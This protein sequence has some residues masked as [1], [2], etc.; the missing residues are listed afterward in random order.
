MIHEFIESLLT[1]APREA[2]K[3]GY[4]YESI[5]LMS[6]FGRHHS[7]WREHIE[8]CHRQT[9]RA[10]DDAQTIAILGS[11]PLMEIPIDQ[12]LMKCE[13]IRLVDFVHPRCVRSKWDR[14][15]K[16]E[17]IEAD[18]L[19][20]AKPLLAWNGGDL[21]EPKP[22]IFDADFVL[23]ANCLSQLPLKP[24]QYLGGRVAPE[25][26]DA[27]SERLSHAHLESLRP[28]RH[29]IIADFETRVV[30]REGKILE[31]TEPFFDKSKLELV[32]SWNWR[33]APLGEIYRD[34]SVEMSAGAFTLK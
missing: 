16:V 13:R 29:L 24:R 28:F 30:D 20:I 12:L 4:L 14:H 22:A 5:A 18:L 9:L 32:A 15:P 10:L 17:F 7:Q 25:L 19:G 2:R 31:R 33:L 27:Y 1:K 11:G 23:S 34:R 26:L 3:L 6:R 8:N 21:P